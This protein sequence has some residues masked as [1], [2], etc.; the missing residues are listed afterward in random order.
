MITL[1]CACEYRVDGDIILVNVVLHDTVA[2]KSVIQLVESGTVELTHNDHVYATA[3]LDKRYGCS[4]GSI[5]VMFLH[6]TVT[7]GVVKVQVTLKSGEIMRSQHTVTRIDKVFVPVT[8]NTEGA[9][10]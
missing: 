2:N 5:K 3:T 9:L 8:D 1:A 4:D 10:F 6:P 7:S